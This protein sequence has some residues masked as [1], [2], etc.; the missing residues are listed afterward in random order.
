VIATLTVMVGVLNA[1]VRKSAWIAHAERQ[2]VAAQ[3][4]LDGGIEI[5]VGHLVQIDPKLRWH[6]DG[7]EYQV[8]VGD[9][10]MSIRIRD[11]SGLID[12]N[13]A[14][15]ALIRGLF[16]QFTSLSEA[17][18]LTK[19]ITDWRNPEPGRGA[20]KF[21]FASQISEVL[22]ADPSLIQR[23]LPF[24][25]F[26][27]RAGGINPSTAPPEVL[28]SLP[29][30]SP[31]EVTALIRDRQV[32]DLNAPDAQAI[33]A[34]FESFLDRSDPTVFIV[35]VTASGPDI[36]ASSRSE[37]TLLVD[38]KEAVPYYVLAWSW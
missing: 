19:R 29:L 34:K 31:N 9:T 24:L 6:S 37:A 4:I 12:L 25:T 28:A 33:L 20:G 10:V 5:A 14:D 18:V 35:S 1:T 22:V 17:T 16:A 3:A 2:R 8:T 21:Q 30:I 15:E 23:V 27:G 13:R 36:L 32:G 7:R 38:D 26:Y 11:V